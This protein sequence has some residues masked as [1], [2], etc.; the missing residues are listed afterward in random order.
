MPGQAATSCAWLARALRSGHSIRYRQRMARTVIQ[1]AG[2]GRQKLLTGSQESRLRLDIRCP[3]FERAGW[4]V[5]RWLTRRYGECRYCFNSF[6]RTFYGG[7]EPFLSRH[8][9]S[10]AALA[11]RLQVLAHES[12][13]YKMRCAYRTLQA[14]NQHRLSHGHLVFFETTVKF[15]KSFRVVPAFQPSR[16]RC[17]SLTNPLWRWT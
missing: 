15:Q 11:P 7:Q 8:Y 16:R 13:T 1:S 5:A 10:Q 4:F 3:Q 17:G 2:H 9:A 14:M 12:C 6:L